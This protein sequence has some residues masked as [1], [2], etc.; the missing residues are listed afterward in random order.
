MTEELWNQ[1]LLEADKNG[2]GQIDF[3]EFEQAMKDVFRKSWLR[4]CDR[5]PSKS[6]SPARSEIS[7]VKFNMLNPESPVHSPNKGKII[8]PERYPFLNA[9]PSPSPENRSTRERRQKRDMS[10]V[11]FNLQ[12]ITDNFNPVGVSGL[13]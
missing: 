1:I 12:K 13:R 3:T 7:P 11:G 4:K 9:S 8:S 10:D 2:D 5:S 6:I